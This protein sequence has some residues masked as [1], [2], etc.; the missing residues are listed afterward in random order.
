MAWNCPLCSWFAAPTLKGVVRHI[1]NCHAYDGGFHVTCGIGGCVRTYLNFHSYKNH[2]YKKHREIIMSDLPP[3][4]P[5]LESPSLLPP[6]LDDPVFSPLVSRQQQPLLEKNESALF[7][8][9]AREVYKMSQSALD[10]LLSDVSTMVDSKIGKMQASVSAVL[11]SKGIT[12]DEELKSSFQPQ[13]GELFQGLR[14]RY[15]QEAYFKD[16]FKHVVCY[17]PLLLLYMSTSFIQLYFKEPEE[18]KLGSTIERTSHNGR[19]RFRR[20]NDYMY[21]IPLLSSLKQ[22]LSNSFV[23]DEVHILIVCCRV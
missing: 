19:T 20:R 15:L 2:L 7:I 1:G 3:Q 11:D 18:I 4:I 12:I 21:Y 5:T 14:T 6:E 16:H 13:S 9:K 22:L 17:E 8:L 10:S 23:F